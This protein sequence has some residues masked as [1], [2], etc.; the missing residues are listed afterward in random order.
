MSGQPGPGRLTLAAR[1]DQLFKTAH[2]RDRRELTYEEA[3]AGINAR[4]AARGGE[5]ISPAYLHEL[6]TGR[7]TNP[8]LSHLES[9]ADYFD[10]PLSYLVGDD[11]EVAAIHADL[12]LVAAMRDGR[13]EHIATRA[14]GQ[15]PEALDMIIDVVER[16]RAIQ[17]LPEV[18]T[19]P[20]AA[21]GRRTP[22]T[23]ESG[24]PARTAGDRPREEGTE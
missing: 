15:S 13:I 21:G 4:A 10:V 18:D 20:G 7:K 16:L 14:L 2:P 5:T 11:E 9:I 19:P 1:I 3:T 17:Q 22:G 6:R 8:R 12:R 24:A 23:T